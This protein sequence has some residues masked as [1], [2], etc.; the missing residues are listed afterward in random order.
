MDY[1][2]PQRVSG[3]RSALDLALPDL[4]IAVEYDGWYWHM[5]AADRDDKKT[6][7]LHAAGWSVIRIRETSRGRELPAVQGI[8]VLAEFNEDANILA[9]RVITLIAGLRQ[10]AA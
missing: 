10:N 1:D 7:Q 6:A 4:K 8:L 3:C 5:D 9:S 2:G